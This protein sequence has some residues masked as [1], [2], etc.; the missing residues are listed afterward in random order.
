MRHLVWMALLAQSSTDAQQ[1]IGTGRVV[2]EGNGVPLNDLAKT[3][4]N[5]A[6]AAG[7]IDRTEAAQLRRRRA[8]LDQ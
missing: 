3:L 5:L 8:E 7:K 1:A 4:Q 6:I 2:I